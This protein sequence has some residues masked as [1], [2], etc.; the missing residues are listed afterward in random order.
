MP[1][2]AIAGSAV[3]GA[4]AS[5]YSGNKAAK[6][7]KNAAAQQAFNRALNLGVQGYVLALRYLAA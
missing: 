2:G 1:I 6:A 5:I 4:G 7:Q 3:I